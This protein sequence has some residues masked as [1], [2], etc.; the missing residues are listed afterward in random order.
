MKLL[1]VAGALALSACSVL[2]NPNNVADPPLPD[3]PTDVTIDMPI[4]VPA[5]APVDMAIDSPFDAPM[6]SLTTTSPSVVTE[7]TGSGN[8]RPL[9]VIISGT[10][11]IS[12]VFTIDELDDGGQAKQVPVISSRVAADGTR[13]VLAIQIPVLTATP[14]G[15]TKPL[16]LHAS[17]FGFTASIDL[18]IMGLDELAPSGS[19]DTGNLRALY[20]RATFSSATHFTG[21]APALI[22]VTSDITVTAL[23][24]VD[25]VGTSPGAHGCVAGGEAQH[26]GCGAGGG[27]GGAANSGSGGGGGFGTLGGQ[28]S[29]TA[30]AITGEALL[31]SLTTAPNTAGNRGNGGGGGGTAVLGNGDAG[32]AGAGVVELTA[33]GSVTISGN[34][35]VRAKGGDGTAGGA[36]GGGT[37]GGGSGGAILIRAGAGIAA[38][39]T[40]ASAPGGAGGGVGGAGRIRIDTTSAAIPGTPSPLPARGVAWA[41]TAPIITA[42][43]M[44]DMP[45][46]GSASQMYGV[47]LNG[48]A[49]PA[50]M[51]NTS[52]VAMTSVA[53]VEGLNTL[54]ATTAPAV[55][56]T[57]A[58]ASRCIQIAY[59][60]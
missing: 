49:Q 48:A 43:A 26:G 38:T 9:L 52:G 36:L 7:G 29:A 35:S 28:T 10:N 25:G 20:S 24:E 32:G 12:P 5:D 27:V 17:Q 44:I 1:L 59:L 40:W 54:C 46:I 23:V 34:G 33:D 3:A 4:D 8:S 2:Y 19:V 6:L 14:Q 60:P 58:E 53:L 55:A 21:T 15:G 50:V 30:G 11:L 41:T 37:G 13:I 39:G 45:L 51:T 56:V 16:H 22:R 47:Y 31:L 18:T 57:I 42:A